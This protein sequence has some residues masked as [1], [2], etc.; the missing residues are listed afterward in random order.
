[1]SW[2]ARTEEIKER[3]RRI[4]AVKSLDHGPDYT[5]Q[6]ALDWLYFFDHVEDDL[7]WAVAELGKFRRCTGAETFLPGNGEV[8]I[9]LLPCYYNNGEEH[10]HKEGE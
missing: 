1:M 5:K 8:G 3:I 6:E 4:D 9:H 7:R 10:Y 2:A